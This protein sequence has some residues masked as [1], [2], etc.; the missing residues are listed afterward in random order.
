MSKVV[1]G[2][3]PDELA[4]WLDGY[5]RERGVSRAAVLTSALESVRVGGVLD[6]VP[7]VAGDGKVSRPVV[8]AVPGVVRGSEVR[9][10]VRCPSCGGRA[11]PMGGFQH[12]RTCPGYSRV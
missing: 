12:K 2:R 3:V 1:S 8:P 11:F 6:A 5:A 10:P 4:D 9:A 7:L